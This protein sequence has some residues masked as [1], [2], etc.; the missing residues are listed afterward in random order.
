MSLK[1]K[2]WKKIASIVGWSLLAILLA[3]YVIRLATWESVYYSEKEGSERAITDPIEPQAQL[4][5][6]EPAAETVREYTVA[7]DRP[8]YLTIPKLG[9]SNARVLA[10]GIN[11]KGQLGTPNNIYDVGWYDSSSKPGQP[12][13]VLIDGHKGGSSKPGVFNDLPSLAVGDIIEITRGDN[14][15][16]KYIVKENKT[17]ALSESNEYMKT[18]LKS[19]EAGKQ[20]V[21]LISCT[22]EWNY[23]EN[24]YN[25]RQFTR[26][27]LVEE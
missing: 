25:S 15:I 5:E 21:T 16:F 10:V 24:T 2:G 20:S 11:Q 12:G 23:N 4:D 18:A 19:P 1:I 27:V 7:A 3:A 8:R 17:V 6:T 13:T 14:V 9:I 26:A 22:G